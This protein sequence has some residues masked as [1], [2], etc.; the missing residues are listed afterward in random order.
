MRPSPS[1]RRRSSCRAPPPRAARRS[2]PTVCT[3]RES[4]LSLVGCAQES[5]GSR[6][7]RVPVDRATGRVPPDRP[8]GFTLDLVDTKK[9]VREFLTSRRARITPEQVG[10]VSYG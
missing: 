8:A 2:Y 1:L 9:E 4:S 6:E 7:V 3:S 5:T 10:L